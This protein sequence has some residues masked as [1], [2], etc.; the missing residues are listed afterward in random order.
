MTMTESFERHVLMLREE[1][2]R[3][4]HRGYPIDP[5]RFHAFGRKIGIRISEIE[6]E[7][8]GLIPEEILIL[9]PKADNKKKLVGPG[10]T[11]VPRQIKE[12]LNEAG[13]PKDGSDR[14][15]L[16]E[17]EEEE[18]EDDDGNKTTEIVR[19]PIIY[20][21]KQVEI[22]ERESGTNFELVRWVRLRSFSP[23]SGPQKISYIILR[24]SEEIQRRIERGQRL[25]DAE[26]LAHY[27]V[28]QVRDKQTKQLKDNTGVKE[29]GKL[30]EAT[31]DPVFGLIIE[32]S[33]LRKLYSTY[34]KGFPVRNGF[35]HTTFGLADT[36]TGQLTS[37][38]PNIQNLPQHGALA[39]EFRFAISAKPGK[40]L[41]KFDKKSFHAQTLALIAKDHV[42]ARLAK[43]DVHSFMTAHRLKL[44][45]A[46]VL[47]NWSDNDL[48][49]WFAKMKKDS[50]IYKGEAGPN[51]K[52]GMT[53]QEVRD[54]KAKKVILGI[55]FKQ[56]AL[57]I[58]EQNKE[59]YKNTK[60][61]QWFLDLFSDLFRKVTEFQDIITKLAHKQTY[62][63][64]PWG[65]IRHFH[66]VFRWDPNKWNDWTGSQGDWAHGDDFEAAV[67]FLPANIA[68][69]MFKEETLRMAGFRS[70]ESQIWWSRDAEDYLEK[71]GFINN[72]HDAMEFHCDYSLKEEAVENLMR[73]TR[74]P[75][76]TLADPEM[77]PEGFFVDAECKWGPDMTHLEG[78]KI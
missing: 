16:W 58:Y 56:G 74:E 60:E 78:V 9:E 3:A 26:R 72:V 33:K 63:I 34:Y 52:D 40:I 41:I 71:Y 8:R 18:F 39:E 68:F 15:I 6:Q 73:I 11:G 23:N 76:M 66:D 48:K 19:V 69:G 49:A 51:F 54:Y 75:C 24:R 31:K 32:I 30:F 20:T 62:L 17:D 7:I 61:V 10:F 2:V 25:A 5:E 22:I 44:P 36:G 57:S 67:A 4:S 65:Y 35:T 50:F 13:D 28:P 70:P 27:Y 59:G 21:R 53:F 43:I 77:C 29:F 14:V 1:M 38:S 64:S 46:S 42:Y 47:L 37:I 55:G 45:E 12:F